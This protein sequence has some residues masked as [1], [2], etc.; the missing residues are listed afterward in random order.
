MRQ[1]P[2]VTRNSATST[3]VSYT[4]STWQQGGRFIRTAC[5]LFSESSRPFT[6]PFTSFQA[7]SKCYVRHVSNLGNPSG[8]ANASCCINRGCGN[9][10][11]PMLVEL[12]ESSTA[13]KKVTQR[14]S[15]SWEANGSSTSQEIPYIHKTWKFITVFRKASLLFLP[16]ATWTGI[17][18]ETLRWKHIDIW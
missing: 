4:S 6:R 7:K 13:C 3:S 14:K 10:M 11:Q 8:L 9:S 15:C 5:Q 12:F 17:E 1:A 18:I 2:Q 16:R